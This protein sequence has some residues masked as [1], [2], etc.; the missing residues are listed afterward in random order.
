VQHI[1]SY[2]EL[3]Q[4]AGRFFQHD[5]GSNINKKANFIEWI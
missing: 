5:S 4:N 3:A 2:K 1:N